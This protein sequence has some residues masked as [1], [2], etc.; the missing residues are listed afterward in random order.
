[1]G[2]PVKKLS[3]AR[4]PESAGIIQFDVKLG[5]I[6]SNKE[7]IKNFLADLQPESK[8][9]MV[10]PEL[11]ASGFDYQNLSLHAK[12]TVDNLNFLQSLASKYSIYF[13]GSLVEAATNNT[14]EAY[15]NSLFVTGPR[16]TEGVYR[17][18][19]LFG[20]MAEDQYFIPGTSP[21]PIQ[22]P[23]GA[24]AGLVCYDLRFPELASLQVSRG[25]GVILV[26][27]QWPAA[28][29]EHWQTL[30]K[31]R[32]IENQAY[33]VAC[34]RSGTT[35]DIDFAGHSIV[36]AP[37]GSVLLEAEASQHCSSV[38]LDPLLIKKA[39]SLFNTAGPSPYRFS[40]NDKVV[41]TDI[42]LKTITMLKSTGKKIVFTNGC[43]DILHPG[44]VTYLEQA[45][46]QGDCL[47]VGLNSDKSIRS[48][49]GP[50]RPINKEENR[51][52]VLASLGCV[53][54]VTLFSEDTPHHL[55]CSVMPDILVKGA[56][57]PID[58]IIGAPEVI[59]NGGKVVNV[60]TVEN[61]STTSLIKK[62]S[63]SYEKK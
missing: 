56:D 37:D 19:Q 45:R 62:I 20:P 26:S 46:K 55:I 17:K 43:F 53:D 39:R 5:D 21:A 29:L 3:F 18:Q 57:W 58:T 22:T 42:L 49:K 31:A 11:W 63:L 8:T 12:E 59:N 15:H 52:R 13:A 16:G 27:A 10:L 23:L 25:A 48:I 51:A 47:V 9:I 44:H 24:F 41:S 6:D 40:D 14:E 60:P 34:N 30:L 2:K 7:T 61:F 28:R 4:L 1:M 35:K 33:L 50:N 54:L 38:K 36:I 32:A